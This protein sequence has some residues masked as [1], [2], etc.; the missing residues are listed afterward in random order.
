MFSVFYFI[1]YEEGRFN[2]FEIE[3]R[4]K[5]EYAKIVLHSPESTSMFNAFII[6]YA[7]TFYDSTLKNVKPLENMINIIIENMK[8][9]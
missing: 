4:E 6:F 9:N 7:H 8:N 1:D 3:N 5:D 2:L